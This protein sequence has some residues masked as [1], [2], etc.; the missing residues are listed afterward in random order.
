M[1]SIQCSNLSS[2]VGWKSLQSSSHTAYAVEEMIEAVL[3]RLK[4][5]LDAFH[6]K[7]QPA[8]EG[9]GH[10]ALGS[11]GGSVTVNQ[12]TVVVVG[13]DASIPPEVQ[14]LI[15]AGP[16]RPEALRPGPEEVRDG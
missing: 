15:D 1:I 8:Q 9:R 4:G 12:I 11:V 13:Q 16:C 2:G 14:K 10:L 7:P 6:S 3:T 5:L